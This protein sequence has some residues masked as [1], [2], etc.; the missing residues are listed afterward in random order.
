LSAVSQRS[1]YRRAEAGIG[2]HVERLAVLGGIGKRVLLANRQ[3]VV[4]HDGPES[5]GKL[6]GLWIETGLK[7]EYG[8]QTI[9]NLLASLQ[10]D[11]RGTQRIRANAK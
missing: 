10:T 9:R 5:V 4:L 6:A 7:I 3:A 2:R 11:K 8:R 1:V